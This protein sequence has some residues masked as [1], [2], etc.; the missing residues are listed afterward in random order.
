[1]LVC[2]GRL[3]QPRLGIPE[4]PG[5]ASYYSFSY[6]G[7]RFIVLDSYDV[8]ELG[9]PEDHPLHKQAHQWLCQ[10]NPNHVSHLF[11]KTLHGWDCFAAL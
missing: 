6:G 2:C 1:M 5:G 8:S 10:N 11:V 7:F 3:L 9:W 4:A